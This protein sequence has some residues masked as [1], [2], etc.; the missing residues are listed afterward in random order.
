MISIHPCKEHHHNYNNATTYIS[1][2]L[3]G[4]RWPTHKVP[5]EGIEVDVQK[6]FKHISFPCIRAAETQAQL[7]HSDALQNL[8]HGVI[9]QLKSRE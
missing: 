7:K 5:R 1:L 6:T 8:G 3:H 9:S 4:S 2:T